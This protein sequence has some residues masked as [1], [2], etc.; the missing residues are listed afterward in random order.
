MGIFDVQAIGDKHQ[1][2]YDT[3]FVTAKDA[4]ME[5]RYPEC[6]KFMSRALEEYKLYQ[7]KLVQCRQK[8][9]K[10]SKTD[11][12]P[13]KHL[14]LA[15]FDFAIRKSD[16]IKRCKYEQFGDRPEGVSEEVEEAFLTLDTYNF[17]QI[18]AY[19]VNKNVYWQHR[20]AIDF[21]QHW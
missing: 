16:C 4:Y 19:K 12:S 15:F 7:N 9:Q 13:E 14:D 20:C 1:A 2:M 21:M 6:K 17:L 5:E 18:C 3:L 11:I 10:D 8:C